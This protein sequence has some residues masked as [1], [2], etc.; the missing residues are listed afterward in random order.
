MTRSVEQPALHFWSLTDGR[1]Q[2]VERY[3]V[4]QQKNTL[5]ATAALVERGASKELMDFDNYLDNTESDWE[6]E[7]LNR[8][9]NQILALY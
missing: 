5:E 8:D 4:Q 2:A 1:W 6:N 3:S 9:L 7:H